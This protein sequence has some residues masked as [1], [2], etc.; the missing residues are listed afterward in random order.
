MSSL[1][2]ASTCLVIT[3]LVAYLNRR[4]LRLPPTIG[5]MAI[6]LALSVLL[7]ALH[8]LGLGELDVVAGAMLQSIDFSRLLMQGMLSLLL[9]AGA[10]HVDL[11]QL[12]AM[13]WQV[14]ALA[15][16]GTLISAPVV[17]LLAWILLPFVG[18]ELP[19]PY[20]LV[21]GALISPTDPIAVMG[22]LK[23]L[24]APRR[25]SLVIAGESLFNDGVGVV[26][27]S[28]M[29][30]AIDTGSMPSWQQALHLLLREA[31]G[32]LAFG[33]AL[34]A[35]G[36]ALLRS[37]DSY[38]EEVLLTLAL[39]LGGYALANHLHVSGPLAM[40]V[41]GLVVGNQG[42]AYAMSDRTREYVDAFWE[43]IDEILNA[44]LFVLIGLGLIVIPKTASLAWAAPIAIA[45]TLFARW[46]SAGL[47]S[48]LFRSAF[49][50]QPGA[51]KVL[52]WGGLRG[53]IS[54]ALALSL[55]GGP[56]REQVVA[57]TYA[58]VVFSVLVQGLTIGRVV[59]RTWPEACTS[60]P[61]ARAAS[62]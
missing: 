48:A 13:R 14:G 45:I 53:G 2:L 36:F 3:A 50:L 54:V 27:F 39:V 9:F 62:S 4:F 10:L 44:V 11:S 59:R 55:P 25:V 16:V 43:L 32:G 61:P 6:G 23:S 42:R 52:T 15:F 30:I 49:K 38:Q 20:C 41:A 56:A 5:V 17:G 35:L 8:A 12:R 31:V 34:G 18:L 37:I 57:L 24:G 58:V 51:W 33:A 29:A 26:L 19:L 40:V 47:P 1:D 7:V 60:S 22:I 28:L 46:I 21:F